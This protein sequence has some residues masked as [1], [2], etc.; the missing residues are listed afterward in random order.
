MWNVSV[1]FGVGTKQFLCLVDTYIISELL[2]G[3]TGQR[4]RQNTDYMSSSISDS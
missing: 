2:D 1:K 3:T 4:N